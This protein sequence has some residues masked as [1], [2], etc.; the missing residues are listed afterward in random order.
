MVYSFLDSVIFLNT[1]SSF[2][3]SALIMQIQRVHFTFILIY[4][5]FYFMLATGMKE[6]RGQHVLCVFR[7]LWFQWGSDTSLTARYGHSCQIPIWYVTSLLTYCVYV[8]TDTVSM[9]CLT[10]SVGVDGVHG[11]SPLMQVF[12][13]A[14]LLWVP[15][16]GWLV[17]I[18]GAV[19]TALVGI[20]HL[21]H[22]VPIRWE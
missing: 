3:I 1:P 20:R 22:P 8:F 18:T 10:V 14:A 19:H 15:L 13:G 11:Y 12:T 6:W 16:T 5:C 21:Y 2:L 9:C 17:A 4:L 7:S